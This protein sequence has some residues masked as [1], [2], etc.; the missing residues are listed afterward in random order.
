LGAKLVGQGVRVVLL[1]LLIARTRSRSLHGWIHG[2]SE[3]YYA[4]ALCTL[5]SPADKKGASGEMRLSVE[6]S[7]MLSG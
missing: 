3:K 1:R 6:Y 2:V 4:D 7:A 5:I